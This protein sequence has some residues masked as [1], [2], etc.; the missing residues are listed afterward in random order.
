M[1]LLSWPI[2]IVSVFGDYLLYFHFIIFSHVLWLILWSCRNMETWMETSIQRETT[3]D[4]TEWISPLGWVELFL[5]WNLIAGHQINRCS[6]VRTMLDTQYRFAGPHRECW[7]AGAWLRQG[8]SCSVNLQFCRRSKRSPKRGV[9]L[10]VQT[11]GGST[12]V[13][14]SQHVARIRK[15]RWPQWPVVI[16]ALVCFAKYTR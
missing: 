14:L 7:R 15:A 8:G 9:L 3:V 6:K 11:K 12:Q 10:T 2:K 4:C 13:S 5:E 16:C 1:K